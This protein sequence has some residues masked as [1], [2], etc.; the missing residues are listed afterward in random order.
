MDSGIYF[1]GAYLGSE[2]RTFQDKTRF[3][4]SIAVGMKSYEITM[5]MI[6]DFSKMAVGA[7]LLIRAEINEYKGR[8]YW[9][10]GQVCARN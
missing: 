6:S 5:D 3:V 2:Q 4:V 7:P 1:A 10:H 8:V 9:Q